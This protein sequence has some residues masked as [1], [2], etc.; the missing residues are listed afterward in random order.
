ML[1]HS[2]N[3]FWNNSQENFYNK[4]K[5]NIYYKKQKN[6]L[7]IIIFAWIEKLGFKKQNPTAREIDK[8]NKWSISCL[9]NGAF[10]VPV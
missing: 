4:E 8:K 2:I 7:Q 5:D 6:L 3:I 1:H 9:R 10:L